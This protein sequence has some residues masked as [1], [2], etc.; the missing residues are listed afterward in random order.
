MGVFEWEPFAAGTR[1]VAEAIAELR[2]VHRRRR[3]RLAAAIRAF[4]LDDQVDHVSTGGGASLELL[5]GKDL[6]AWWRSGPDRH[7]RRARRTPMRHGGPT[8]RRQVTIVP[9]TCPDPPDRDDQPRGRGRP[10]PAVRLVVRSSAG[11]SGSRSSPSP[12]AAV[13][14]RRLHR[15]DRGERGRH[16]PDHRR[17]DRPG[18][19]RGGTRRRSTAQP[20]SCSSSASGS[21]RPS[22]SWSGARRRVAPVRR[23][24]P[25]ARGCSCTSS[26]SPCAGT[27]RGVGDLLSTADNDA[28][29]ATFVLAPLPFATGVAFLLVGAVGGDPGDR[30][31]ARVAGP[32]HCSWSSSSTC[33]A[34]GAPSRDGG[35]AASS[36]RRRRRRPRVL[37]RGADGQV[38]RPGGGR[39]RPVPARGGTPA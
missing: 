16:R 21:G 25:P 3:R 39:G 13:G 5:E 12:L 11:S 6:P 35:G 28:Q 22:A 33:G 4:G 23:P 8:S 34:P 36:G 37:R 38:A 17:A 15:G 18:P 1:T 10:P 24:A 30:R 29:Q 32:A 27:A 26:G 31:R 9:G 19:R 20:R 7:D 14:R 2:R